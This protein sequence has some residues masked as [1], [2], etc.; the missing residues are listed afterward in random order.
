M[1]NIKHQMEKSEAQVFLESVARHC[2]KHVIS[3]GKGFVDFVIFSLEVLESEFCCH[4]AESNANILL[5][6]R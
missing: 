1:H 3:T 5:K 2:R 6:L 4:K